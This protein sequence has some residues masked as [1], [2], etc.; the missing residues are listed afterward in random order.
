MET[1]VSDIIKGS[2]PLILSEIWIL[3]SK[4]NVPLKKVKKN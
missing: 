1:K 4:N 2:N 3:H